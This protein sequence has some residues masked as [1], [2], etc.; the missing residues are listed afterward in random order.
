MA[1]CRGSVDKV[2]AVGP[3]SAT[4]LSGLDADERPIKGVHIN[5]Q[6]AIFLFR[7]YQEIDAKGSVLS[8]YQN[9]GCKGYHLPLNN[10]DYAFE[11]V[12]NLQVIS[13]VHLKPHPTKNRT[14]TLPPGDKKTLMDA[15]AKLL[16]G[17]GARTGG[18]GRPG[19]R[20]GARL[21]R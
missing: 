21:S 14:F 8:G 3:A 9:K 16:V 2:R 5:D 1:T 6:N 20:P 19:A 15:L 12:S 17:G 18:P 4:Y 10:G 7:W 13:A 11:W